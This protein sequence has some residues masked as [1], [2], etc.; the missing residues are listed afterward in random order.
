MAS[1]AS[2][3]APV[4]S[5]KT[6]P[7]HRPSKPHL[8][9][10]WDHLTDAGQLEKIHQKQL[11][12]SWDQLISTCPEPPTVDALRSPGF[13]MQAV[14]DPIY[15][16]FSEVQSPCF[17]ETQ[18]SFT[19]S[20]LQSPGIANMH[21]MY[22]LQSPSYGIQNVTNTLSNQNYFNYEDAQNSHYSNQNSIYCTISNGSIHPSSLPPTS[23]CFTNPASP[24]YIFPQS[25]NIISQSPGVYSQSPQFSFLQDI[26][27]PQ[28]IISPLS[29]TK[30]GSSSAFPFTQESQ[31]SVNGKSIDTLLTHT[32]GRRSNKKKMGFWSSSLFGSSKV[33]VPDMASPRDS[34]A[35]GAKG[36]LNA[37]GQNN[38]FLNSAVQ[39]MFMY[40]FI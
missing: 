14:S 6:F 3:P 25:P 11:S 32:L 23:P 4:S 30:D 13:D 39:V 2:L 12:G 40:K 27:S 20:D 21:Q 31:P 15:A 28:N 38:C 35:G 10:S 24:G 1:S 5:L 34:M 22:D 19:Y 8:G 37:P 18:Q 17:N 7:R 36:L 26:N 29:I 9:G 16:P 33:A